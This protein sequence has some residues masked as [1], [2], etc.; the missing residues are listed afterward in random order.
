[1]TVRRRDFITLLGGAAANWP[2]AAGAQQ[3]LPVIGFL[4]NTL[5]GQSV[6]T[7]F[8]QGLSETGFVEGRNVA[9]EYR[10]AENRYDRL[11][12]LAAELVDRRVAVIVAIG[13]FP[14]AA[15]AKTATSTIPVVF[16]IS[17]DPVK[18]GLVASLDRPGGNLTGVSALN[19]ETAQK[20]LELMHELIPAA[21]DI[22]LLM[23]PTNPATEYQLKDL[24]SAGRTLG[25]E[26]HVFQ[27]STE[28]DFDM[29]FAALSQLRPGGLVVVTDGLFVARSPELAGLALQ[30]ALPAIF[31]YREFAAAGGLM[32]YG[33][34]NTE[35]YRLA[36]AYAGRILRGEKPSD[37]PV[38]RTT[39]VEL[40]LNLK[41]A[42]ALGRTFPLTLLG[43]ADEVIE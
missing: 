19:A 4:R 11:P 43:R 14:L 1:M 28:H 29:A 20:R 12:A 40:I 42:R 2:L 16:G 3:A 31:Q 27:A 22:A 30:Y 7:A 39:K 35:L 41:T 38:Q 34:S 25:V 13:P 6:E 15:T 10:W 32:S 9:I 23:N 36:G 26:L 33:G 18:L 24:Q 8:R 21:H 5:I 17:E 37:L